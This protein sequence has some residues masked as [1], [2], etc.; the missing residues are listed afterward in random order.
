MNT[1]IVILNGE[2]LI[3]L[4]QDTAQDEDVRLGKTYHRNDGS[5]GV[6]TNTGETI[7][8]WDGSFTK[9]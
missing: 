9:T 1:N 3:N 6:G 8:E 2:T 4:S 7:P 5:L